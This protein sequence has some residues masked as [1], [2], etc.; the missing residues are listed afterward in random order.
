M[1][2]F[3]GQRMYGKVDEIPGL[4]HVATQFFYLQF[5]PLIPT[6][7]YF[8]TSETDDG[9]QGASISLSLKSIFMAWARTAIVFAA[10]ISPIFVIASMP[11]AGPLALISAVFAFA[12]CVGLFYLSKTVAFI[13]LADYDRALNLALAVGL[14]ELGMAMLEF[15]YGRISESQLQHIAERYQREI[16]TP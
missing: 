11:G 14:D 6:G 2:V 10:L 3:W 7:S 12:A 13:N 1:I 16:E 4:G 8:I 5:I 15:Q 9:F